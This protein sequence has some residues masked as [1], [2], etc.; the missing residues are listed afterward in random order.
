MRL[1]S[2]GSLTSLQ[3]SF[4]GLL[5]LALEL[6]LDVDL[7]LDLELD[8]LS[9]CLLERC[10]PILLN[11]LLESESLRDLE[12]RE[13][14]FDGGSTVILGGPRLSTGPRVG[15]LPLRDLVVYSRL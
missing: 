14:G 12:L 3:S 15:D 4:S 9:W 13:E 1:L 6:L 11:L 8:L 10:S 5:E 7:L 2:S